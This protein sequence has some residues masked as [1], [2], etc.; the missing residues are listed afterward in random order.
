MKATKY[1]LGVLAHRH[2]LRNAAWHLRPAHVQFPELGQL[3]QFP[4]AVHP[5]DYTGIMEQTH[6][7]IFQ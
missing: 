6:S 1:R 7:V 5:G 3:E 2:Q 4:G